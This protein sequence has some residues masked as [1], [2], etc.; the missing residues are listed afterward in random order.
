MKKKSP[1]PKVKAKPIKFVVPKETEWERRAR[2][3]REKILATFGIKK[4]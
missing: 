4:I 3:S 1:F 2:E